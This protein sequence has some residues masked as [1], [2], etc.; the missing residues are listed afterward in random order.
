MIKQI[1]LFLS[2]IFISTNAIGQD[3]CNLIVRGKVVHEENNEPIMGA[4]IW[5]LESETGAVTDNQ[6]NFRIQKICPGEHT[7]RVQFLGHK[8]FVEKL[9]IK[10]NTN[11]TIRML[12][13]DVQLEGV[14]IHGHEDA[15]LTTNT[16]S[17]IYGEELRNS[18]GQNLGETLRKIPGITTFSSGSSIQKPVIH[19]LHSNR[20]LILNNGVRLEG[21]QWG[22]DHAPEIDPF[23][24]RE[25]SV[26][27]G[28]ETVRFGP[29]AMGGVILVNPA[30]LP[31]KGGQSGEVDLIGFSNGRG[32]NGS[33]GIL[34]GSHKVKGSG[35]WI[36]GSSKIAGNLQTPDYM[37]DNTGVRELNFSGALGFSNSRLGTEAYFSHFQASIGILTDSHTGNLSDLESIIENGRPF[38]NPEFTYA[39]QNPQQRVDHQLVKV[40]GHYHLAKG[41][42]LNLQYAFQRNHRQEFDRRRG[43]RNDRPALDLVLFTNTLDFSYNHQTRKNWNG[44]IGVQLIQQANS[45]IPGTGVIPLIPNY[46]MLNV[47]VFAIEKFTSGPLEIE[48]G[49]RYDFRHVETARINRGGILQQ[50]KFNFN[51]FTAFLGAMY[52]ISRNITFNTN[53]GTAWRP[54]SINEQ[55]SQGLHHGLAAIEIGNPDFVSEQSLK[56]MNTLSYSHS[57][58]N[59]ELTGYANIINNYIYLNPTEDRFVSLRG[60]FNV[61]EYLQTDAFF[62]GGDLSVI[63]T[64]SSNWEL[65]SR[66]SVVRAENTKENSFLPFIPSDRLETGL[67]Y[68]FLTGI[69]KN[70]SRISLSNLAVAKQTREPDF[71][72]APAPPAYM[73]WNL[74]I[75]TSFKMGEDKLNIG[76]QVTNLFN[77]TYKDYMNR[78]RYFSHELGRN[79]FLK[80]NYEF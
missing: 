68:N 32:I 6:G 78:F 50:D 43:E 12:A 46:D 70:K 54:P 42:K 33:V 16:I 3:D 58:L 56:W 39:I 76:L 23:V 53:L 77:E 24:A 71:D 30:P 52:P 51:N 11:L 28:A 60:T 7:I 45:N 47:G 64:I 37:L 55:F 8:E 19:G 65:F 44:S 17:G 31:V 13:E 48:G 41:A 69:S 14:D 25:I 22:A 1:S 61:F 72:L 29:D 62:M 49:L 63:W 79:I 66:G 4:Y 20:I 15:L 67:S 73:L 9:N 57:K 5:L 40:K 27:K 26:V 21:Q 34:G 74:G 75:Q 2:I 80:L 59:V 38:R 10:S 35:Y 36:Q 18:R